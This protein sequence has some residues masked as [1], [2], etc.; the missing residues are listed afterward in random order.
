VSLYSF[1]PLVMRL[2]DYLS[3]HRRLGEFQ[4][5]MTAGGIMMIALLLLLPFVV[6]RDTPR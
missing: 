3:F 2:G 6:H 4:I 5:Y 1:I